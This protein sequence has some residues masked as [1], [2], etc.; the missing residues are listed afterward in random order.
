MEA[1]KPPVEILRLDEG[2]HS[3]LGSRGETLLVRQSVPSVS[4]RS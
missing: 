3:L 2:D 4:H 1:V